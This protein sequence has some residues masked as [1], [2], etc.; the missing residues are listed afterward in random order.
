[1]Q[2]K[3]SVNNPN[4]SLKNISEEF[5]N[6]FTISTV[7]RLLF[8]AAFKS[9]S[10]NKQ[11]VH[12]KKQKEARVEFARSN[13]FSYFSI[14]LF[15]DEKTFNLEGPDKHQKVWLKKGKN[16]VVLNKIQASGENLIIHITV[17]HTKLIS[18]CEMVGKHDLKNCCKLLD[19]K[20]FLLIVEGNNIQILRGNTIMLRYIVRVL[21]KNTWRVKE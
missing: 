5:H 12:T 11:I 14:V 10:P 3:T 8:A 20:V 7:Q 2:K 15:G 1:M 17:S 13:I 9:V 6:L 18:M 4:L 19:Q 21:Q 16:K